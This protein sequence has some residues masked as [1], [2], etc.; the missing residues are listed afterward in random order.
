MKEILPADFATKPVALFDQ[1]A[2]LLVESQGKRNAMTIAWGGLGVLWSKPAITVY[3]R[4]SRYTH[5]LL[6]TCSSWSVNF[7]ENR[8][9]LLKY[10]GMV[11]GRDEDKIAASGLKVEVVEHTPIFPEASLVIVAGKLIGT[12]LPDEKIQDPAINERYY[13][14]GGRGQAD[15]SL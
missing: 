7:F 6:E 4:D 3:V 11:S 2:L 14:G 12:P 5:E 10:F 13:T 15:I 9:D 8:R 1:A